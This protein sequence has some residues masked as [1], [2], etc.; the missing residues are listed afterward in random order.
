MSKSSHGSEAIHTS[1]TG[2]DI[3]KALAALG[4]SHGRFQRHTG[5]NKRT[6]QRWLEAPPDD[7]PPFWIEWLL[8]MYELHPEFRVWEGELPL[9]LESW[10]I[11][12]Q[13]PRPP[14][15]ISGASPATPWGSDQ[16]AR[17]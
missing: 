2:R 7:P 3:A 5:R 4:V 15:P 6:V 17:G 9:P 14:L 8:M 16:A 12:G 13:P 11:E 10:G 1:L